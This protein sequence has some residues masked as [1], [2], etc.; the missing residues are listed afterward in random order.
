MIPL[1]MIVT[2]AFFLLICAC[3]LWELMSRTKGQ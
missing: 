1:S 2:T 3:S